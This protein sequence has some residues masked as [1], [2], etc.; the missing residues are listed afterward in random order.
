LCWQ[1]LVAAAAEGSV[2]E[3]IPVQVPIPA[4]VYSVEPAEL[5]EHP[6]PALDSMSLLKQIG[7]ECRQQLRECVDDP[8]CFG[9]PTH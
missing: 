6:E 8:D 4:S 1:A 2:S 3:L 7:E 5:Q 9:F